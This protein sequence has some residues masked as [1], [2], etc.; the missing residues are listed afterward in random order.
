MAYDEELAN[1]VRELLSDESGVVEKKMFGGL[2]FLINGHMSVAPSG[3]GG[4]LVRVPKN[5]TEDL[6]QREHV[7]PM[8]MSGRELRGWLYVAENGVATK[9]QLQSWVDRG[10]GYAKGLPPK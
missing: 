7:T 2:A 8:V 9:R 10:V 4:L 1:R 5:Q 3:Q 6:L